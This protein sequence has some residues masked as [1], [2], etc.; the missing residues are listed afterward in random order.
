MRRSKCPYYPVYIYTGTVGHVAYHASFVRPFARKYPQ[1][2]LVIIGFF[3]F[4]LV[5]SLARGTLVVRS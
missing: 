3:D 2:G 1:T 4:L 5:P